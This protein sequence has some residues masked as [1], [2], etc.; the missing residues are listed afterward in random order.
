MKRS[1]QSNAS[2]GEMAKIR[3]R[4]VRALRA[5]FAS[6][7]GEVTWST[8]W[9]DIFPK[10]RSEAPAALRTYYGP[11]YAGGLPSRLARR[12]EPSGDDEV[13]PFAITAYE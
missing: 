12:G 7:A 6:Y 11:Y 10:E 4:Y 9:G 1:Y 3:A 13:N 8:T 2:P 5:G